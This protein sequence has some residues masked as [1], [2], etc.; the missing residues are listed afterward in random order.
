LHSYECPKSVRVVVGNT[1]YNVGNFSIDL[2]GIKSS[3]QLEIGIDIN[4]WK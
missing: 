1:N 4:E 2:F 3:E